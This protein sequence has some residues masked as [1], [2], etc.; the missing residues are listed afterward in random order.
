MSPTSAGGVR[1]T[2]TENQQLWV[3]RTLV[4][5]S[6]ACDA[7]ENSSGPISGAPPSFGVIIC[8]NAVVGCGFIDG[9]GGNTAR[10]INKPARL[11]IGNVLC[12]GACGA[13]SGLDCP[14]R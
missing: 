14:I 8:G 2:A 5:A 6:G 12:H 3:T 13:I 9:G 4:G 7:S 1:V 10:S 11:S